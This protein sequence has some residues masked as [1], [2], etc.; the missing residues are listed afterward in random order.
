MLKK[1]CSEL[2]GLRRMHA[3]GLVTGVKHFNSH[4]CRK[5]PLSIRTFLLVFFH[6]NPSQILTKYF[7]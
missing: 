1:E 5:Q 6:L 4:L 3:A 7:T 2:I